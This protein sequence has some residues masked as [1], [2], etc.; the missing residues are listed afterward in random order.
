MGTWGTVGASYWWGCFGWST[1]AATLRIAAN[2]Y[3]D[4]AY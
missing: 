4:Y 2:G 1:I 3:W